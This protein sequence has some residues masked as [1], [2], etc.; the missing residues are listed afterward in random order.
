MPAGGM[1]AFASSLLAVGLVGAARGGA[2]RGAGASMPPM[3]CATLGGLAGGFLAYV[4]AQGLT[5]PGIVPGAMEA[6]APHAAAGPTGAR[7]SMLL[8]FLMNGGMGAMLGASVGDCRWV[9]ARRP[10]GVRLRWPRMVWMRL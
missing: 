9:P 10:K 4:A 5:G 3:G 8:T 1:W 7:L 2:P 6:S